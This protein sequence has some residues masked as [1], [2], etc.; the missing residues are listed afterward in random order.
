MPPTPPPGGVGHRR[1]REKGVAMPFVNVRTARGLLSPARKRE[2]QEGITDLL[3]RIE[4]RG[5]PEFARFV[6]VLV[7]EHEPS[8]WC[9]Q[10]VS[11]TAEAVEALASRT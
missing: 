6:T 10:G 9:V 5:D 11:F 8:A 4:G 3:V 2:L 1:P 7:E